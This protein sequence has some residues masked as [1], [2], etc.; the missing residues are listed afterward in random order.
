ML[1]LLKETSWH[2]KAN[3]FSQLNYFTKLWRLIDSNQNPKV[4]CIDF[5]TFLKDR[6]KHWKEYDTGLLQNSVHF[7]I[8][9]MPETDLD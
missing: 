4:I 8:K 1:V 3:L 6:K 7:K 2:R 5:D 9:I